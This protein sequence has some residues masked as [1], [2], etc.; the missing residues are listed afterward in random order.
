MKCDEIAP[1]YHDHGYAVVRQVFS[2]EDIAT[3]ERHLNVILTE[4]APQLKAGEVFYEDAPRKPIKSVFRLN[5]HST[6]FKDLMNDARLVN[7][8]EAIWPG[9]EIL[10]DGV[11]FFGKTAHSGSVT[12]AHQ[13]NAFQN[14]QPPEKLFC[15]IAIDE[16][17][18]ENGALTVQSGSHRLGRLPHRASGVMGFSQTLIESVSVDDYP[19]VQLCMEPGDICLHHTNTIHY[20]GANNSPRSRRQ[21][22]IGYRS[23]RAKL[24]EAGWAKYQADLRDLL[25]KNTAAAY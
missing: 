22:A 15:T 9:T 3:I 23:A 4:V 25:E 1:Y 12:P 11:T 18:S 7:I 8:M 16:S 21:L 19:A 20:S 6:F 5:L 24:D 17:T 10:R 14:L 2:Q 13:D